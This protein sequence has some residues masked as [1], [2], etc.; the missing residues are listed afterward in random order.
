MRLIGDRHI[1]VTRGYCARNGQNSIYFLLIVASELCQL[2]TTG[3]AISV[4]MGPMDRPKITKY[5]DHAAL[6]AGQQSAL[7]ID[8]KTGRDSTSIYFISVTRTRFG[9]KTSS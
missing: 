1:V 9:L 6:R 3:R 2:E 7:T 8:V 5:V 4:P